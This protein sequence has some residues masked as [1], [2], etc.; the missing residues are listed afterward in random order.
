MN[1]VYC[2]LAVVLPLLAATSVH[3]QQYAWQPQESGTNASLEAVA[4]TGAGAGWAVGGA[5]GNDWERLPGWSTTASLGAVA[6]RR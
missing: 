6:A 5:K 4:F 2:Y 1:R 3:P